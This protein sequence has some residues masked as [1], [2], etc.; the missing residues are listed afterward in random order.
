MEIKE[1][2]SKK[3]FKEY[4]VII[5]GKEIEDQIDLK[6]KEIAP[7]SNLPGFR[8]GKAPLNLISACLIFHYHSLLQDRSHPNSSLIHYLNP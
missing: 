2:N 6:I 8:P 7:K 1:I 4:E 5:P 3:L